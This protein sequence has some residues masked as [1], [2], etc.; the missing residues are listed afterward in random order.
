MQL[1]ESVTI[2]ARPEALW[3]FLEDPTLMREWNPKVIATEPPASPTHGLGSTYRVCYRYRRPRALVSP[4]HRG[5]PAPY[6]LVWELVND[7]P[8]VPVEGTRA[9]FDLTPVR[10]GIR[11]KQTVV[12]PDRLIPW[13]VRWLIRFVML[14]GKPQGERALVRLKRLVEEIDGQAG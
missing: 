13:F 14:A 5:A 12:L 6:R 9:I 3:L 2:R 7:T 10:R 1:R 11:L 4:T 8:E